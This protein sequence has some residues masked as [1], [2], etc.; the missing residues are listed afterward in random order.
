MEIENKPLYTVYEVMAIL[1]C[2]I[3]KAYKIIK[4]MNNELKERGFYTVSGKVNSQYFRE[5][6]KLS[7]NQVVTMVDIE[8]VREKVKQIRSKNNANK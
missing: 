6:F 5:K 4:E 8:E 1:G 2:S 7:E 3:S